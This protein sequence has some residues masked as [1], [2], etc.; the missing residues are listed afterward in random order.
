MIYR[1][2]DTTSLTTVHLSHIAAAFR[3]QCEVGPLDRRGARLES[4]GQ[5]EW[6]ALS[7]RKL[8]RGDCLQAYAYTWTWLYN[9]THKETT[10]S[11]SVASGHG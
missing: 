1:R 11:P 10:R 6:S 2:C 8:G 5:N 4:L 3:R 9:K 7:I